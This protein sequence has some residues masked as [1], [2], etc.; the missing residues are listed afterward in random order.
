MELQQI[1]LSQE[2]LLSREQKAQLA[3]L[4]TPANGELGASDK[5]WNMICLETQL[6]RL[7]G[8]TYFGLKKIGKV[9]EDEDDYFSFKVEWHWLPRKIH[10]KLERE[11]LSRQKGDYCDARMF[12]KLEAEDSLQEVKRAVFESIHGPAEA[13]QAWSKSPR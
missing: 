1:I 5:A 13:P 3:N 10:D 7:W 9:E 8:K 2:L 6:H 12:P 4:V 11:F